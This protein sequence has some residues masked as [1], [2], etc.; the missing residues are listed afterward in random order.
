MAILCV[1][2]QL[3]NLCR[4]SSKILHQNSNWEHD[5]DSHHKLYHTKFSLVQMNLFIK[6]VHIQA[7]KV[8]QNFDEYRL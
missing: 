3:C 4:E 5:N 8:F 7:E 6:H 1:I 2:V